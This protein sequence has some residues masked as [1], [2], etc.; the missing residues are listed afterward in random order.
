MT[1][2]AGG[3]NIVPPPVHTRDLQSDLHGYAQHN[4]HQQNQQGQQDG[5]G[6]G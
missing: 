1:E 4:S 2:Q 6:W 3:Y 5:H